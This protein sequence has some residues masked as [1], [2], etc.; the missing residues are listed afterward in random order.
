MS[1]ISV[2]LFT[3]E[4][5]TSILSYLEA[6][7]LEKNIPTSIYS[8]LPSCGGKMCDEI[9]EYIC[10]LNELQNVLMELIGKTNRFFR[11]TGIA[12]K[13]IDYD[14]TLEMERIQGLIKRM[15]VMKE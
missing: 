9:N 10:N 6:K 1:K 7:S 2:N 5:I 8:H 12:F 15:P 4:E 3:I 14:S 13:Q 11:D